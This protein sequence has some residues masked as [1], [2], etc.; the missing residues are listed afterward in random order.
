M[1]T[2]IM[3]F[4]FSIISPVFPSF[5]PRVVDCSV[6][7]AVQHLIYLNL[8]MRCVTVIGVLF[9]VTVVGVLIC[10]GETKN[11]RS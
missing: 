5:L 6:D 8:N 3:T 7:I 10:D 4:L 1:G 9:G 2:I 11:E